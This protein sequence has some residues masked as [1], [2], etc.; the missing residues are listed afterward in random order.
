M[1]HHHHNRINQRI[2]AGELQGF[3]FTD[4]YPRIGKAL[5]LVFRTAPVFRSIRPHRWAEYEYILKGG[6]NNET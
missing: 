2:H 5:V 3:Y 4:N 6:E 1:Y